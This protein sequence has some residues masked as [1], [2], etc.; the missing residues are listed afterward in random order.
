MKIFNFYHLKEV[1]MSYFDH[2]KRALSI[3]TNM[4]FGG[5]CCLVHSIFPFLFHDTATSIVKKLYFK[6]IHIEVK[7]D[8]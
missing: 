1:D 8:N 6:Y 5:A 7:N 4:L 3:G 2:L